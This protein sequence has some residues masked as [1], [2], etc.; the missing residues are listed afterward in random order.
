MKAFKNYKEGIR[1]DFAEIRAQLK[2][3][4]CNFEVT[5]FAA[6]IKIGDTVYAA[7]EVLDSYKELPKN[8]KEG[9]DTELEAVLSDV[10]AAQPEFEVCVNREWLQIY[11][12]WDTAAFEEHKGAIR[13][14]FE[15]YAEFV[16]ARGPRCLCHQWNGAGFTHRNR[17]VATFNVLTKAG[18]DLFNS[19]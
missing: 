1:F 5:P 7:N 18:E 3:L 14:A 12:N 13:A 16:P 17:G 6:Y 8:W 4:N 9:F 11:G 10:S 15:E 19:I 2:Q